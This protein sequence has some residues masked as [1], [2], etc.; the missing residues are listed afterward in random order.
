VT[1]TGYGANRITDAL[2]R[3]G[4][5]LTFD[6]PGVGINPDVYKPD[7]KPPILKRWEKYRKSKH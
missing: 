1:A 5:E 3:A 4:L 2:R 7:Q 6:P